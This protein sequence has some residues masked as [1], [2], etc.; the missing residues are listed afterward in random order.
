MRTETI[1]VHKNAHTE[2]VM[3]LSYANDRSCSA[4]CPSCGSDVRLTKQQAEH[5][6]AKCYGITVVITW[7]ESAVQPKR[8]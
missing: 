4:A 6:G 5:G 8:G 3:E 1:K 2:A 7:E